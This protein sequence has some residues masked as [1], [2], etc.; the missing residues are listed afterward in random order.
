VNAFLIDRVQ[1][2]LTSSILIAPN[3]K[4]ALSL[5]L[6]RQEISPSLV[7]RCTREHDEAAER[8]TMTRHVIRPKHLIVFRRLGSPNSVSRH[9]W[10]PMLFIPKERHDG[11]TKRAT[12]TE[13]AFLDRCSWLAAERVR[14]FIDECLAQYPEAERPEL[15]ARFRC[16][17]DRAFRSASFELLLH[18]YLRR[19]GHT[20]VA[21]PE[22]P[23]STSTKPDFLVTCADGSSFYLEAVSAADRDGRSRAGEALI[24][25]TLQHLTDATHA[26]FFVEVASTGYPDS[27]PSGRRLAADVVAWLNTLDPDDAIA[28]MERGEFDQLPSMEWNHEEWTLTVTALPCRPDARGRERRLI[29]LQNFGARWIDGWTPIRDA[30]MTKARQYG[31]LELP[32][33]VAVNVRSHNL[34]QIDE[35]QAL[36]GQEQVV[37][38]RDDPDVEPRM[39]RAR[40]GAWTGPSGPRS[41]RCSG[42]W[43]FHDVTPYTVSRRK[44]TLYVNPWAPFQVPATFLLSEA[45][46]EV[47]DNQLQR[48]EADSIGTTLGLP[49]AW[50]E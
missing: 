48:S 30:V 3:E 44:H 33:V 22:L 21:H 50:P 2:F 42:A 14:T 12:E 1:L 9:D 27:Q 38:R 20:L 26:S 47:L 28:K 13:F 40:N 45:R 25:T 6:E 16:G 18:E 41:R 17:D 32:L 11:A 15:M 29:G 34:D 7:L 37:V 46:A 49:E 10:C 35:M 24:N 43:L 23:G 36:F 4:S 5:M 19:K 39:E 31:E 8:L